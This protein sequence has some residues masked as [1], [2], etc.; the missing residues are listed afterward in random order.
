MKLALPLRL[1][2]VATLLG[3]SACTLL[4]ESEPVQVYQM[5]APKQPE[6]QS[7]NALPVSLRIDTPR[8]GFALS[9]PRMLVN[10]E[11]DQLSTYKGARWS[12]PVPTLV[13]DHLARSFALRGGL[14]H[15]STEDH[16][17]Y[18]DVHMGT[19][20]R[21]FQVIY[22]DRGPQ[23]TIELDARLVDPTNRHVLASRSFFIEQPLQNPQVPSVVQAYGQALDQL[24]D[25][26][27][28]WATPVLDKHAT[29]IIPT[30]TP[31]QQ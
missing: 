15:V 26:L 16:S 12:D 21:S 18:A 3:L 30:G 19:D 25:D 22:G 6:A 14:R 8:A 24:A 23:A 9:G 5:P 4:P 7:V 11:G 2:A 31:S 13:R 29:T 28:G 20:L 1:L 10:P 27:I 17:L